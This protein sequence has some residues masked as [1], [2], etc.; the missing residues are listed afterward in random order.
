MSILWTSHIGEASN[1]HW[2]FW[3][4]A[5]R[6]HFLKQGFFRF[7][8]TLQD[9]PPITSKAF[10]KLF[11]KQKKHFLSIPIHSL[12]FSQSSNALYCINQRLCP[13]QQRIAGKVAI[14]S[15]ATTILYY[16]KYCCQHNGQR[17]WTLWHAAPHLLWLISPSTLHNTLVKPQGSYMLLLIFL[18][19]KYESLLFKLLFHLCAMPWCSLSESCMVLPIAKERSTL[20]LTSSLHIAQIFKSTFT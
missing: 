18:G 12:F 14:F 10:S 15:V 7:H 3:P 9:L 8:C 5:S 19:A 17:A 6:W 16:D 4:F 11:K 1:K 20:L 2:Y 13:R